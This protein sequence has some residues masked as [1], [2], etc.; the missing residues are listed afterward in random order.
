MG[1]PLRCFT[2][3]IVLN[4]IPTSGGE[5]GSP[6]NHLWPAGGRNPQSPVSGW[7][8]MDSRVRRNPEEMQSARLFYHS[9]LVGG[10]EHEFYFPVFHILGIIIPTDFHIFLEG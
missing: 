2:I 8:W 3:V 5:Q 10:L 1:T 4:D 6:P 9:Y 7:T